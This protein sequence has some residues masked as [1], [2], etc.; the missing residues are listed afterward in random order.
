MTSPPLDVPLTDPHDVPLAVDVRHVAPA[1]TG[2]RA[3]AL[4]PVSA[5]TWTAVGQLAIAAV[6]GL[7]AAVVLMT[8]VALGAG[9]LVVVVGVPVLVLTLA[10][11][12]GYG[13]GERSR[14][15][16]Q[17]GVVVPP[18]APGPGPV[19][20][21]STWW[22]WLRDGRAWAAVAHA[23]VT[24]LLTWTAASVALSLAVGALVVPVA[25]LTGRVSW[26]HL[27]ILAPV[28][29]LAV[30]LAAVLLQL[31]CLAQVRLGR[32]LLGGR[33]RAE[34]E[35]AARAAEQRASVAE[36]RAEHLHETR[37]AAVVAADEERRRIER[38][39]H[40][41]AQQRL[42]ALGVELGVARRAA[43]QDPAVA[44]AAVDAAH[45]EIKEVLA[46]LRDLVR[47]VHPAVLTDRGLDAALSALAARSPV[48]VDVEADGLGADVGAQAQAAAY[49]VVAEA[50]TN[51]AKHATATRATVRAGVHGDRLRIEVADDGAGAAHAAPGGG[52]DGL[53]RRVEALDGTFDLVSPAGR[54]TVLT[55][56]VPCAS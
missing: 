12:R 55:V 18:P 24:W 29:V 25:P 15:D 32:V 44:V 19:Y 54:G 1:L 31:A 30:W 35:R 16:A 22:A 20:R 27:A 53:R 39:L 26:P 41:G 17:L 10:L 14:L 5:A 9:L 36:G 38:D 13:T 6:A 23:L 56:E 45:G 28:A 34:A 43:A 7:A 2:G 42:V 3:L 21:P 37:T 50:L 51:V 8:G 47:G 11:A 46:E 33:S 48:P 49:F 52:L 4:A 40:D